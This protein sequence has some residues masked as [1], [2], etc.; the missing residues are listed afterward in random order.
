MKGR[1]AI[2][3]TLCLFSFPATVR[4]VGDFGGH[5][6]FNSQRILTGTVEG[7]LNNKI[8]V[9]T[10]EGKTSIFTI[11][12]SE[13]SNY[14]DKDLQRGDR[15]ILSYDHWN[16]LISIDKIDDGVPYNKDLWL[17]GNTRIRMY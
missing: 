5:G 1:L 14:A 16:R 4:A 9:K 7:V 13:K 2:L 3:F 17:I 6:Q 11:A 12:P 8:S 15:I 10:D